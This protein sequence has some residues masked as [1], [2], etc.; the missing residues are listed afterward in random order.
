MAKAK[1]NNRVFRRTVKLRKVGGSLY[2]AI[3]PDFIKEHSLEDEDE[4]EVFCDAM[5]HMR[6]PDEAKIRKHVE[7]AKK[8]LEK[9]E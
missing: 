4:L 5:I 9:I 2:V 8:E 1:K 7:R 3:P 6:K